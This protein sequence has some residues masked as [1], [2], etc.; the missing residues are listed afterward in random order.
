MSA[1]LVVFLAAAGLGWWYRD[2]I[3]EKLKGATGIDIKAVIKDIKSQVDDRLKEKSPSVSIQ[4]EWTREVAQASEVLSDSM[5]TK[6]VEASMSANGTVNGKVEGTAKDDGSSDKAGK[7]SGA[8]NVSKKDKKRAD[9]EDK[10]SIMK[11]V[12][13]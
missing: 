2:S 11:D 7:K 6:D 5:A 9:I 10:V 4:G 1:M 13:L 12:D 8:V 3:H